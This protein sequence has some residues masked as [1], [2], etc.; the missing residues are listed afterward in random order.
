MKSSACPV[1][2]QTLIA[3]I[4]LPIQVQT[5]GWNHKSA[6]FK[7]SLKSPRTGGFH[8]HRSLTLTFFAIEID[9]DV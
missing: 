6:V 8:P 7:N 3:C 2:F 4:R 5:I 1:P 9:L